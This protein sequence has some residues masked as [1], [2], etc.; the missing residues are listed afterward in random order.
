MEKLFIIGPRKLAPT[1]LLSLQKAAVVQIDPLHTEEIKEYQLSQDEEA[2]LR[3]WDAVATSADHALRLLGMEPDQSVQPFAGNLEEAEAASSPLE[4]SAA[5]L[6]KKREQ[7][8][9]EVGLINQY[10]EIIGVLAEAGQDL[11]ESP[12]LAV[13][14]F[15][16]E[17]SRN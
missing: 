8:H 2:C 1:I 17:R 10:R 6:V 13:L 16:L 9:D 11:D 4:Q 15:L 14:P 5:V 7:L 12:R 3:R